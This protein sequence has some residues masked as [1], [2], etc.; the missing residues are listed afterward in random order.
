MIEW[1]NVQLSYLP[2]LRI[3]SSDIH[4]W[5]I[6]I[7]G[8]AQYLYRLKKL[9]SLD[10]IKKAEAYKFQDNIISYIVVRGTLRKILANYLEMDADKIEFSYTGFGKP[11]LFSSIQSCSLNFNISHSEGFALFIIAKN[12]EVGIDIERIRMIDDYE[13]IAE[14]FFAPN[15]YFELISI[16]SYQRLNAFYKCWTRKEAFIKANGKG[17]SYS[18]KDFEVK[19]DANGTVELRSIKGN[20]E[21]ARDW[22]LKSFDLYKEKENTTD[23]Y[24]AAYV[25]QGICNSIRYFA[26]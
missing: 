25:I 15:E 19:L 5:R 8:A 17:L 14:Q 9:L 24:E 7:Q 21:L 1:E 3:Q 13:K 2:P 22:S 6:D 26:I 4:V 12:R 20:A 18:L 16:P 23:E 10:E 11:Y